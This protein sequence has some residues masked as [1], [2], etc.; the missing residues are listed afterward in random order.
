MSDKFDQ[1]ITEALQLPYDE[2]AR[3]V[4][5][6]LVS[7]E[8][9]DEAAINAEWAAELDRRMLDLDEGRVTTVPWAEVKAYARQ[10]VKN[11]V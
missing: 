8:P 3:L 5:E 4:D 10:R 6:L 1:I 2:R 9:E 11:K 7:L